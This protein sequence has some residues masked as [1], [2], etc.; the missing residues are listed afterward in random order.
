LNLN[1]NF[2][3]KVFTSIGNE[4]LRAT[5][6]QYDSDQLLKQRNKIS[7]EIKDGLIVRAA[8]FNVILDDVSITHLSFSK[9]Y[10]DAIERKQ[11]AQQE[12]E[13]SKF[14]VEQHYQEKLATIMRSEGEAE[15]AA[16]ISNAVNIHGN[17]KT[18]F[19]I[20]MIV[21]IFPRSSLD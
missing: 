15:G 3:N 2:A 8:D 19:C 11:V 18:I 9:Q 21:R 5:V 13:K 12:A 16:L 17:G 20:L 10:T 7:Q 4:V 6:A 14:V 1:T